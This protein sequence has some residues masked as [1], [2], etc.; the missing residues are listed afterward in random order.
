MEIW[1]DTSISIPQLLFMSVC[2]LICLLSSC[3]RD[4]NNVNFSFPC[5]AITKR[6][7]DGL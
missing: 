6:I 3:K 7:I 1:A 5:H 4:M 2:G